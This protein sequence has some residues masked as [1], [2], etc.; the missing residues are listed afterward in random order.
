MK[1]Q[2][3]MMAA[4]LVAMVANAQSEV[5]IEKLWGVPDQPVDINAPMTVKSGVAFIGD[6]CREDY[7]RTDEGYASKE[8]QAF[9]QTRSHECAVWYSAQLPWCCLRH[10]EGRRH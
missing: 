9:L 6:T 1:K 10:Q 3:I 2:I 8:E 4:L 7:R 5:N